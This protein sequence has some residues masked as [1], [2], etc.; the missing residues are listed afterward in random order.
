M[1]DDEMTKTDEL[2]EVRSLERTTIAL[3]GERDALETEIADLYRR[4]GIKRTEVPER[5]VVT[6]L[7]GN[8]PIYCG[9]LDTAIVEFESFHPFRAVWL[10][11]DFLGDRSLGPI[12][13]PEAT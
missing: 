8:D 6:D 10:P 3:E 7:D 9:D 4:L 11:R 2:R 1:T 12:L 13:I 5:Y